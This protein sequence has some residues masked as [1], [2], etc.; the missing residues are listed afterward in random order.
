MPGRDYNTLSQPLLVSADSESGYA[1]TT[2]AQSGDYEL[3]APSSQWAYLK[4][5]A[6]AG[7]HDIRVKWCPGHC[8]ITGNELAD[9]LA[10]TG[11]RL[12]DVDKDCT[13]TAYGVKSLARKMTRD[14]RKNWWSQAELDLS[15]RYRSWGL[16]YHIRCPKELDVLTRPALHRYLAIRTGHGDFAWYH[17]RFGHPDAK[18]KCSCGRDKDPEHLVR[19]GKTL[20]T[21]DRWPC[22]P[23][24][25]PRSEKEAR[26]YLETLMSNPLAFQEFLGTTGFYN[27]ICPR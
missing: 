25:R 4:F 22:R 26:L 2:A 27:S 23:I 14:L 24:R 19:C 7:T 11:A 12:K 3:T 15:E 16:M 18:L 21:F 9:K 1:W 8:N 10:K 13:P 5:H 17:R 6:A 20:A